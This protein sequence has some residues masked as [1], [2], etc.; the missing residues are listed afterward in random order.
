[1]AHHGTSFHSVCRWTFNAG[2]GGFVPAS[3]R[4]EW[5]GSRLDTAGAIRLIKKEIA[6][7]MPGHVQLGFE[8]HYNT[9]VDERTAPAVADAL[10]E[11]QMYLGMITPGAHSHFGYGG[12]ASP[13]PDERRAAED[14]GRKTVDL[15]Y[16]P[17]RPAWH[18]D[19]ALAPTLVL[20]NG[21]Y[22][23]DLASVGIKEMYQHLKTSVAG[24]CRYEVAAGGAMC[25]ALEPKPNE[26]HPAML[27]PTVASAIL[28]WRRLEEEFGTP[29][30]GKG[31]NKEFGHSEMIGLDPVYDS[32]EELDNGAMVHMHLN[33]QGLNDGLIHGGPGKYDIDHGARVNGL[34]VAIAGLV[35][36]AG[37]RRWKGHDMQVRPYDDA[38]QGLDRVIRSILSW[39]A[40][41][42][43]AKELDSK[44]L[45]ACL[46]ARKTAKAE[47]LMRAAVVSAQQHF[48][49]MYR[50]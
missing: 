29:R 23:Y 27:I 15:V 12:I 47:D 11:S 44:A 22:G 34:N 30:R 14:L 41:E 31:V 39:E 19:G 43:A 26:G 3:M 46:A 2:K 7:R 18:P 50:G 25:V 40:C 33:S 17:L 37:Y 4:P 42:Q 38:Q 36:E 20:W 16:G 21:S 10:G 8:V 1:M 13:D 45:L 5:D 28:F 24:L 49:R 6:P 32:V 35:Q 9:E 48:D